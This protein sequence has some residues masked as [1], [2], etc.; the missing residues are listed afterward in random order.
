VFPVLKKKISPRLWLVEK[1]NDHNDD[2]AKSREIRRKKESK[3]PLGFTR[4]KVAGE[5]EKRS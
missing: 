5:R 4:R 2:L 3:K 1:S